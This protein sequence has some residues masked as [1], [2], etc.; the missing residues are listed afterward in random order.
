M[1]PLPT[2]FVCVKLWLHTDICIW[3]PPPWSQRT[4]RV[5]VWG[6]SGTLAKKRTPKDRYGAQRARQLRPRCI[7][8]MRS[9]TQS[10]INQSTINA[11]QHPSICHLPLGQRIGFVDVNIV[12]IVK[13]INAVSMINVI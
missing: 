5:Q 11:M 9:R 2:F 3:A 13:C 6:P 8:T 7:R 4:L 1:K 12:T 10:Q